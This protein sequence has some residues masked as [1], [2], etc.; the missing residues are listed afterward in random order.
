VVW[1]VGIHLAEPPA[2]LPGAAQEQTMTPI[3]AASAE[4]TDAPIGL[5]CG[6]DCTRG[7]ALGFHF[8]YAYQPIVDL[9]SRSIFAHEALVR[10][11]LGEPADTVLSQVTVANR[12]RFDQACRVN[13]VKIASR[14]S[15][16]SRLSINFM[17]NAIYQPELCL[18]TTLAAARAHGFPLDRI[19]FETVEG[20]RVSDGKW[21]AEI[22]REY[23]RAGFMTAID[24]FGAGYAGLN[25][26]ADFQPD[27]VKLDMA[28]VRDIDSQPARQAIVRGVARICDE[29]AITVVAEGVETLAE[30]RYLQDLG[31]NLLQGH[32]FARPMFE[33][34]AF[35]GTLAWP[36]LT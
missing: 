3:S 4:S 35:T 21:L 32:L 26:L 33:A 7:E 28:L 2:N 10:G 11:P 31:V 36:E 19:M 16:A 25:L 5:P 9:R 34:C 27:V 15:M 8:S 18:R 1:R 23:K 6:G 24:D 17:P 14:L 20:E 12:Y 22:L 30:C 29:L 13:A